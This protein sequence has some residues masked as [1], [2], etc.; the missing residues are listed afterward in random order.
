MRGFRGAKTTAGPLMWTS[1]RDKEGMIVL[2]LD[3]DVAEIADCPIDLPHG[4]SGVLTT[5]RDGTA[6]IVVFTDDDVKIMDDHA[7]IPVVQ[8]TE[9][10]LRAEP[11][12]TTRQAIWSARNSNVPFAG[13]FAV[14]SALE[15]AGGSLS[16]G[17][18]AD[19]GLTDAVARLACDDEIGI[20]L[21]HP[22]SR[23]TNVWRIE[24]TNVKEDIAA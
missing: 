24:K 20:D 14:L 9:S 4:S 15:K 16:L 18:L 1:D 21:G 12:R 13:R 7:G 2:S 23:T 5:Q 19:A 6:T 17:D 8:R 3:P 11:G 10:D 22:L